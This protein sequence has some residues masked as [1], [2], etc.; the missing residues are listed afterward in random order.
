MAHNPK[1][2]S[3]S[4]RD[5]IRLKR[6]GNGWMCLFLCVLMAT[7]WCYTHPPDL[8]FPPRPGAAPLILTWP[9][10][11]APGIATVPGNSLP[12]SGRGGTTV[13]ASASPSLH[14][15]RLFSRSVSK[16]FH[17]V[18]PIEKVKDKGR[19]QQCVTYYYI[20]KCYWRYIIENC[21][22]NADMYYIEFT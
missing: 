21:F 19:G 3:D 8:R 5:C 13:S 16:I 11:T 6:P 1:T 7:F 22:L 4:C 10:P 18:F 2:F 17:F 15:A 14:G 9:A 20:R 12:I